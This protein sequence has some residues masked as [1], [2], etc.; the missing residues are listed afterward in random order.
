MRTKG[1]LE[2]RADM[3]ENGGQEYE[4]PWGLTEDVLYEALRDLNEE[5]QQEVF[6]ILRRRLEEWNDRI[7][8]LGPADAVLVEEALG[9]FNEKGE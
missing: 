9:Y 8:R 2:A 5:E 1:E 3:I 7:R 4:T 6:A